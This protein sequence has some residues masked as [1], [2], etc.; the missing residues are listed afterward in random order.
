MVNK[1]GAISME[2]III[3]ILAL[4]TLVVVAAAF[5]GGMKNLMDKISGI[6]SSIPGSEFA[7]STCQNLCESNSSTYCTQTFTGELEGKKCSDFYTCPTENKA[8]MSP[9]C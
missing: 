3:V 6:G 7:R 1:R 2:T 5:T 8:K 9:S 4:I